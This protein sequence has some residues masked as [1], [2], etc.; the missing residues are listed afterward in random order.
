M[1]MRPK[2]GMVAIASI[3]AA[4]CITAPAH[5]VG[6][7]LTTS[8]GSLFG[9]E[10]S[11]GWRF[12][13]LQDLLVTDLGTLNQSAGGLPSP[14]D[15]GLWTDAGALIA[16]TTVPTGLGGVL[17]SG[18]RFQSIAPIMLSA[19]QFYRVASSPQNGVL[20]WLEDANIVVAPEILFDAGYSAPST[21][22]LTFPNLVTGNSALP[23]EFF[24]ANFRFQTQSGEAPV[25]RTLWVK[26]N[27]EWKIIS[28][29][30]E[31]P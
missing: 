26:D 23:A 19:G 8:G 11:N 17:D 22:V 7:A 6:I 12:Q 3:V 29:D 4:L 24:G 27:G 10:E 14:V 20:D 30:V 15:V 28:Y 25:F 21:N 2:V 18:F 16:S 31:E 5:A 1:S 9:D 13:A